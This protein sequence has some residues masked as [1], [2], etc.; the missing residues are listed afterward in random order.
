MKQWICIFSG[1]FMAGSFSASAERLDIQTHTSSG[2]HDTYLV[3]Y[4]YDDSGMSS[5]SGAADAG[6]DTHADHAYADMAV[7]KSSAP[8][9][10]FVEY[11]LGESHALTR[12]VIWNYNASTWWIQG[13]KKATI[14]VR[15]FGG[16][17][18][19]G[20]DGNILFAPGRGADPTAP[21][22]N[23]DL[24]GI[25]ARF[26]RITSGSAPHQSWWSTFRSD[27]NLD[28][29]LSEVRIYGDETGLGNAIKEACCFYSGDCSNLESTAA[30]VDAG[31]TPQGEG[32]ECFT[33]V[34]PLPT[35]A[36]CFDDGTCSEMDPN[37]CTTGGGV[38]QGMS[39]TC[40]TTGCLLL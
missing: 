26:V 33:T 21:S 20:Y 32:T 28:V 29:A 22:L 8:P 18:E 1:L 23:I 3:E 36:C 19:Q 27:S 6:N 37:N 16:E 40:S 25:T 5:D 4:T 9:P 31:G 14:E 24:T 39:T 17:S 11:D 15:E 2:E 34:C 38:P 13:I 35:E 12:L 10:Y 7:L 30:C